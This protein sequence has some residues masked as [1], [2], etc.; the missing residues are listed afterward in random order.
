MFEELKALF[1]ERSSLRCLQSCSY[2]VRNSIHCNQD[3]TVTIL[4]TD[5]DSWEISSESI[6][7]QLTPT[8]NSSMPIVSLED[9]FKDNPDKQSLPLPNHSLEQ[10][11]C[12][13]IIGSK[14]QGNYIMYYCRIHPKVKNASLGV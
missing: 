11:P 2:F 12:R 13:P 3:V 1:E 10:S 9:F 7:S 6:R 4:V 8:E 14:S 5:D